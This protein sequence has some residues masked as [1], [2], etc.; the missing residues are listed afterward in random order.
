MKKNILVIILLAASSVSSA[1]VRAPTIAVTGLAYTQE[2]SQHF[3]VGEFK[4]N[5]NIAADRQTLTV[6]SS[7]IGTYVNGTYSYLEQKE[8]GIFLGDIKGEILTGTD[9]RLIQGRTFDTGDPQPTKAEIILNQIKTGVVTKPYRQPEVRDVI[10]RIRNGEFSGADYVLFGTLSN[11]QF[12]DESNPLQGTSSSTYKYG[13][14]LV[15]DFSLIDTHTYEIRSAFSAEG[16]GSDMRIF[17]NRGD[18]FTPNRSKVVRAAS[19]SLAQSVYEQLAEQLH[20]AESGTSAS[21]KRAGSANKVRDTPQKIE[22]TV[23]LR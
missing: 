9:F 2:V 8:L 10:V 20:I 3:S 22:E 1:D 16:V 18:R 21:A 5:G 15:A 7:A 23:I 19:K 12:V 11:I 17:S 14:D 6:T 4:S 13:I